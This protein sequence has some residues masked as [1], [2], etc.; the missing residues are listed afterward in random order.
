MPPVAEAVTVF[1]QTQLCTYLKENSWKY[2][3]IQRYNDIENGIYDEHI[4]RYVG[5]PQAKLI[6]EQ[7]MT[8]EEYEGVN[9]E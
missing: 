7:Q 1:S 8:L 3:F 2:G 5:I 4:Y 9:N 6:Y